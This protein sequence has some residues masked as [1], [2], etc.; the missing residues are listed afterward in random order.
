MKTTKP[1]HTDLRALRK[2]LIRFRIDHAEITDKEY[3]EKPAV[4]A[5]AVRMT[6]VREALF[7]YF[8]ESDKCIGTGTTSAESWIPKPKKKKKTRPAKTKESTDDE[9]SQRTL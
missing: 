3:I 2:M 7:F 8:N 1:P 9:T 4:K 5:G 6:I